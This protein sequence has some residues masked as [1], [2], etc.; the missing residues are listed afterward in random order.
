MK[1]LFSALTHLIFLAPAIFFP[2]ILSAQTKIF[3]DIDIDELKYDLYD[4]HTA[5]LTNGKDAKGVL[6]EVYI[7][8]PFIYN[9]ETFTIVEIAANAFS[10]GNNNNTSFTAVHIGNGVEK[11]GADVFKKCTNL[12]TVKLPESLKTIDGSAFN[13]CT[14]LKNI[15]CAGYTLPEV[16]GGAFTD[17][18]MS[19]ISVC[20]P[21]NYAD[22][23]KADG[24]PFANAKQ[25][26]EVPSSSF[27]TKR[28]EM[29]IN[30]NDLVF[31]PGETKE[32][33]IKFDNSVNYYGF[34]VDLF[35][36]EG[37]SVKQ[38]DDKYDITIKSTPDG[39]TGEQKCTL[40]SEKTANGAYRIVVY[41]EN[42][43]FQKVTILTLKVETSP[44]FLSG[45][46]R[47]ENLIASTNG[48]P[49]DPNHKVT[50]I[51]KTYLASVPEVVVESISL[52]KTSVTLQA[53]QTASL[54]VTFN[55]AN[56]TNKQIAWSS[57]AQE[58]AMVSADGLITAKAVGSAVITATSANGKTAVCNVTVE[59]TPAESV[60]I[61]PPASTTLRQ[62]EKLTLSAT[63]LPDL[64]TDKT[65]RWSSSDPSV[66]TVSASG[67]VTAIG[68]G[69]VEITA[70]CGN[71]SDKI[72]L[73]VNSIITTL[74]VSP[75]DVSVEKGREVVITAIYT[76]ETP[77]LLNLVWTS[78]Q[79]SVATVD[80]SGKVS[81][82][83]PG[84]TV[85]T[86]SDTESGLSASCAVTVTDVMYGDADNDGHIVISDVTKIVDYILEREPSGFVKERADIDHDGVIDIYDVTKTLE[87]VMAQTPETV[88]MAFAALNTR[89]PNNALTIG[90]ITADES[91]SLL[92]PVVLRSSEVYS[93]LQFDVSLPQGW[94][95]EEA[96]ISGA[97]ASKHSLR[98]AR[99]NSVTRIAVYS[100]SGAVLNSDATVLS[101]KLLPDETQG[102]SS[103]DYLAVANT[104]G[105]LA[106]AQGIAVA[107]FG[108][109]LKPV[110]GV[111]SP[112]LIS[113]T[114]VTPQSGGISVKAEEGERVVAYSTS[115]ARIASLISTGEDFIPLGNGL[116]IV[117]VG[118][119]SFKVIVK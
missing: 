42:S 73:T 58:V 94:A 97:N 115:G 48:D 95:L 33:N 7:V 47:F 27:Y 36:P 66:A 50:A 49:E 3:T 43:H 5:I 90:N 18:D 91:G 41:P 68:G 22:V 1:H 99:L 111:E 4:D 61:T 109:V 113:S 76:P 82:L 83:V 69:T 23:Y 79:P 93:A 45:E 75:S 96:V 26:V 35:L 37:L 77:D 87:L 63:V 11:I 6:R 74:S 101:L 110:S 39:S 81:C 40:S 100:L 25:I 118:S 88:K 85:I 28:P 71:V 64:T 62:G 29:V 65:V 15:Y 59:A 20:V 67:E 21:E 106:D 38:T 52:D 2:A 105:S 112:A 116:Y 86:V 31:T 80:A 13:G 84:E 9:N 12:T 55:P 98:T 19:G 34:Q 16:T 117:T 57:S 14:A 119:R 92:V 24:S 108:A 60:T 102:A 107:D 70:A 56:A 104:I 8:N 30:K 103:D 44:S 89:S 10:K 51:N 53:T 32:L 114:V 46:I 78:S 17:I 72:S 54:T